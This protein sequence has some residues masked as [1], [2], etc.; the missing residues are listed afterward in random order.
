[1]LENRIRDLYL[2][3]E[4]QLGTRLN[5]AV[6]AGDQA[7]FFL[8]LSM[9]S[10]DVTDAPQFYDRQK[11]QTAPGDL[12]ERFQLGPPVSKYAEPPDYDRGPV[13]GDELQKNGFH[14]LRLNLALRSEPLVPRAEYI[15]DEVVMELPPLSR[16]K[17]KADLEDRKIAR[18]PILER[19][20]GFLILD[21]ISYVRDPA[22]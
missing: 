6:G 9:L 1:M 22:V 20:D 7:E 18:T 21:E 17:L 19:G 8:L 16:E 3:D 4:L 12:R 2:V 14:S 15:K 10:A 13:L 11:E 5:E